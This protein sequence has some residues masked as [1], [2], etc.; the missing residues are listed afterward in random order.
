MTRVQA[1]EL[2]VAQALESLFQIVANGGAPSDVDKA[3]AA[4][5][6]FKNVVQAEELLAIGTCE[7]YVVIPANVTMKYTGGGEWVVDEVE[8]LQVD[9]CRI[10]LPYLDDH[11]QTDWEEHY[12]PFLPEEVATVREIAL[13]VI[14]EPNEPDET[15][16]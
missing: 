1:A 3:L 5:R 10:F 9:E 2:D 14:I 7:V 15:P 11:E 13:T 4:V 6:H 12:F 8:Q 16:L